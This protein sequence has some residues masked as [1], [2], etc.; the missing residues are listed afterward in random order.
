MEPPTPDQPVLC[1]GIGS[2]LAPHL[3][4]LRDKVRVAEEMK[5]SANVDGNASMI[6]GKFSLY[7]GNRYS[8][9]EFLYKSELEEYATKHSDWFT[10]H[11]AFS[12]DDPS[13]K[14]YVQDLVGQ[15]M[16]AKLLLR[17]TT[18]GMLYVCGNRQLPKPLQ[19]ALVRSFR[20]KGDEEENGVSLEEATKDMEN[21]YIRG[22]AQQEVW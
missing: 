11:T 14:V 12:R 4:F 19:E 21:L 13:H 17:N 9:E 10:L 20:M 8:K 3:A 15:T 16:D 22:R 6:I 7:F 5:K 18:N 2:G 1:A